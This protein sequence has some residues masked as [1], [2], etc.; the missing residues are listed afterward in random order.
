MRDWFVL[1]AHLIVTTIRTVTPGGARA[2]IAESLLLKHQ[3]L[4]PSRGSLAANRQTSL[5]DSLK[6]FIDEQVD[7]R[8]F[9]TSSEYIRELRRKLATLEAQDRIF[10]DHR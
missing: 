9:G 3:L 1:I 10:A 2:V 6:D 7:Q 8:G 5:P 4:I